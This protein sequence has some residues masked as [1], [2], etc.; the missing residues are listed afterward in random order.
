MLSVIKAICEIV[1]P[2]PNE[3]IT[4]LVKWIIVLLSM[5]AFSNIEEF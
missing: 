4:L 2:N 1:N 5:V 3:I